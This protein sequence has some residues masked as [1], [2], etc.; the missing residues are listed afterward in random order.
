VHAGEGIPEQNHN[1]SAAKGAQERSALPRT[2]EHGQVD[3]Q[4]PGRGLEGG[5][6]LR[7]TS[8][9]ENRNLP[10]GAEGGPQA[11]EEA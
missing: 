3:A 8:G 7:V 10:I 4:G 11:E 6:L 9:P 2:F 5:P 1:G